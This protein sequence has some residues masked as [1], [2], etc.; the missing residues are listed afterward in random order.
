MAFNEVD[1]INAI[2]AQEAAIAGIKSSFGFAQNPDAITIGMLPCVLHY[3]PIFTSEPRAFHNVW[4]NSITVTSILFVT[5]RQGAGG[6][7]RFVENAAIPFG[8]LWR[9]RF[10]TDSVISGL[11]SSVSA[12]KCFLE[13]GRY[14]VGG[15]DLTFGD[16]E[17]IGW[18]FKFTAIN[19]A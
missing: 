16:T 12:V 19:S 11:L 2:A 14:G 5:T 13:E 1:M 9:A 8:Q 10:Q 3:P 4:K 15:N 6:K 18:T 7:L 17:F